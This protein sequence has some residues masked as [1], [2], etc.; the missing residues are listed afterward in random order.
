VSALEIAI[1]GNKLVK[2][3][4]PR[5][6]KSFGAFATWLSE[7]HTALS[8]D[9]VLLWS[10]VTYAQGADR[11]TPTERAI[12][13]VNAG[14]LEV[15]HLALGEVE[16]FIGRLEATGLESVVYST[17][18]HRSKDP[19]KCAGQED[20]H[21]RIVFAF[22]Q[23]VPVLDWPRVWNA[24]ARTYVPRADPAAKD[25]KRMFYAHSYPVG[26]ADLA[27]FRY[28]NPAEEVCHAA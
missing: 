9:D 18:S 26:R 25:A 27:I 28:L 5:T 6:F 23:P 10:P 4:H 16:P 3:P 2:H 20:A 22:S 24:L 12:V 11:G 19:G 7:P 8:K 17:H 1:F 14:V 13:S 21:L 15:D